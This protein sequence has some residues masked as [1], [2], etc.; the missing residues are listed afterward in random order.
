MTTSQT[1][2]T[3]Q[4][5]IYA[6]LNCPFCYALHQ[7][8]LA[9]ESPPDAH[10]CLI[11]HAQDI[12]HQDASLQEQ[13]ILAT[14][15][16]HVRHRAP[17]VAIAMPPARP[18]TH[19][20]TLIITELQRRDSAQADQLRQ[21]F[22]QALWVDGLNID[23]DQV[24]QSICRDNG[25]DQV[26]IVSPTARDNLKQQQHYWQQGNFD[27]RIPSLDFGDD[28]HLLGLPTPQEL[29]TFLA[30]QGLPLNL[31]TA[32]L[33]RPRQQLMFLG[34]LIKHWHLLSELRHHKDIQPAKGPAH[35]QQLLGDPEQPN[36]VVLQHHFAGYNTI[37]ICQTIRK[38]VDELQLPIVIL[39]EQSHEELELQ[40]LK[41]GANEI[42]Y[43]HKTADYFQCRIEQ[44]LKIQVTLAQLTKTA[45][46]DHLTDIYSRAE[47]EWVLEVEWRRA[48]R[49]RGNLALLMIDI[50]HFKPYNDHYGHL[51]GDDTLR[52]I[53]QTLQKH[54]QRASDLVSRYGG[55]E[56]AIILPNTDQDGAMQ[57]G[58]QLRQAVESLQIPH[59]SP[60]QHVTV[61]A[62]IAVLTPDHNKSPND[63]VDQADKALYHAK[64]L[65]RNQVNNVIPN[66]E[67]I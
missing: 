60:Y 64:A 66:K 10:W 67:G 42:I 47:F 11:E 59:R 57:I 53:A 29:Q 37:D 16:F 1:P 39:L 18:N 22:Y 44:L 28:N 62:G 49:S 36:L 26:P 45:R 54:C 31:E 63:L 51:A 24:V 52:Q 9:M 12:E 35:I 27:H 38:Q 5:R 4:L 46:M 8:F 40:L 61:S 58:E 15:V 25:L 33:Y 32:C 6:D 48:Q 20:A 34:D 13:S 7:R 65:G 14:E 55:E 17:D 21:A 19:K 56:F 3:G 43:T 41:S 50:D 23:D 2:I 30:G